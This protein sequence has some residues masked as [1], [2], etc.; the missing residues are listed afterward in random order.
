[1]PTHPSWKHKQP[2]K[3]KCMDCKRTYPVWRM[4]SLQVV[5]RR[6]F[7][8]WPSCWTNEQYALRLSPYDVSAKSSR[9]ALPA[10]SG[11]DFGG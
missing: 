3:A 4:M 9:W 1:M 8:C 5:R 10:E 6:G 2:R 11:T 7:T